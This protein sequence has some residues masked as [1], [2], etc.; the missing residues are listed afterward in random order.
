M[1][2]HDKHCRKYNYIYSYLL[3]NKITS[4]NPCHLTIPKARQLYLIF[5]GN[6]YVHFV[7]CKN[8]YGRL[9]SILIENEIYEC[10]NLLIKSCK[11]FI[12]TDKA[13]AGTEK[14]MASLKLGC[15]SPR[16]T[17]VFF[18]LIFFPF[19]MR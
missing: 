8:V 14:I 19:C 1:W 7:L 18:L 11:R 12:L 4:V 16:F 5:F 13:V 6:I 15:F 2:L 9:S 17:V 3:R 10:K